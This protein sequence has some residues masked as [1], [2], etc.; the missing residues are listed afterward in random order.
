MTELTSKVDKEARKRAAG[1][2]MKSFLKLVG[3][4]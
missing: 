4:Y 2:L 1:I 3:R